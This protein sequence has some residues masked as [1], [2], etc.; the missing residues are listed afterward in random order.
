ML[1]IERTMD[2]ESSRMLCSEHTKL[3]LLL[4]LEVGASELGWSE[5][6]LLEEVSFKLLQCITP[7]GCFTCVGCTSHILLVMPLPQIYGKIAPSFPYG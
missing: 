3:C 7:Q 1:H 4:S 2:M 6:W 5:L